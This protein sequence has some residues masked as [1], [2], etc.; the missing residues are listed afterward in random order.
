M[1]PPLRPGR[2]DEQE[3]EKQE[4]TVKKKYTGEIER[5]TIEG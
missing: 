3:N 2:R 4:R 1:K 5:E